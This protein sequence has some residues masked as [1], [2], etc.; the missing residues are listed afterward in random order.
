MAVEMDGR[1][2]GALVESTAAKSADDWADRSVEK[3][4]D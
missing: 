2:V 4:A 3:T 1:M